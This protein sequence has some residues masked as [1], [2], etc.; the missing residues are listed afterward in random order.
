MTHRFSAEDER[1][2]RRFESGEIPPG[3][4][5]HRAHVRLAYVCLC[6]LSDDAAHAAIRAGLVSFI[7]RHAIDPAKYHETITRA[8]VLAVRHFMA[9]SP[10]CASADEFLDR[11]PR[12]LDARIMQSHYSA[13]LLATPAA[14]QEFVE[15]D[16]APIPRH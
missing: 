2:R 12:L 9:G 16:L 4:F 11:N 1:F 5:N 6:A 3:E 15:P 14:R 7:R 13:E 10:A 8:W